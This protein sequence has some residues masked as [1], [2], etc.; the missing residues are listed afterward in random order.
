MMN[1]NQLEAL[2]V[3]IR[4]GSF[5]RAAKKLHISQSAVSQRIK[6]LEQQI[7]KL[8]LIRESPLRATKTGHILLD[9]F[10]QVEK[11]EVELREFLDGT[12]ENFFTPLLV[13]VNADSLA[14]WFLEVITPIIQQTK[15]LAQLIV[16]DQ[17]HT[18]EQLAKGEVTGCI[19]A[20]AHAPEGCDTHR[21]GIM[22]Y[23]IVA[24]PK[25]AKY[26]F[27][28]GITKETLLAAPA[29]GFN[30]K[31]T[32]LEQFLRKHFGFDEGPIPK[33]LIPSSHD[34]VR[35]ITSGLA[36]G[37]AP[38]FQIESLIKKR[39]LVD[40]SSAH[41][42]DMVLYWHHFRFQTDCAKLLTKA[43]ITEAPK[44]LRRG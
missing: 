26:Y 41:Y 24:S 13:G 32:L 20:S 10:L 39:R 36:Y 42:L 11:N 37:P 14:T 12:K 31:D 43:I 16:D 35:C 27:S 9:H 28:K 23:R 38:E 22:R 29:V 4:E 30:W 25:F 34:F 5:Y 18:H 17:D 2:Q 33:H 3:V 19:S 7:G 8:L 6:F 40:L 21:L 1:Y 15:S 44:I